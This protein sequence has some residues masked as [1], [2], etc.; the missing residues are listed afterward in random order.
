MSLTSYL[1]TCAILLNIFVTPQPSKAKA[2][3]YNTPN[4]VNVGADSVKRPIMLA[5]APID[6]TIVRLSIDLLV[7]S[8]FIPL[9][10]FCADVT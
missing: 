5:P 1:A 2:K 3:K 9:N 7:T 6:V 4:I 10:N 8:L